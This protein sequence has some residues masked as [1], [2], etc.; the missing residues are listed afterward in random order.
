MSESADTI[1]A[2]RTEISKPPLIL[3]Q[4]ATNNEEKKIKRSHQQCN[5][6][7]DDDDDDDDDNDGGVL[8]V[9]SKRMKTEYD[10]LKECIEKNLDSAMKYAA[11]GDRGRMEYCL[12]RSTNL[13]EQT[14]E[15]MKMKMTMMTTTTTERPSEDPSKRTASRVRNIRTVIT[16]EKEDSYHRSKC[17]E[18]LQN[19][20]R[21]ASK[22]HESIMTFWL[23]QAEKEARQVALG[24]GGGGGGYGGGNDRQAFLQ[25]CQRR[26]AMIEKSIT[27]E[28]IEACHRR[29]MEEH[30]E[31][32]SVYAARGDRSTI[33]FFLRQSR[34]GATRVRD[35]DDVV[36]HTQ[37]RRIRSLLTNERHFHSRKVEQFLKE[38]RG[39]AQN[40]MRRQMMYALRKATEHSQGL[41]DPKD[42]IT[43]RIDTIQRSL[44]STPLPAFAVKADGTPLKGTGETAD[45]AIDLT[46]PKGNKG[47]KN[48]S[49]RGGATTDDGEVVYEKEVTVDERLEIRLQEAEATGKV[50][51]L[52]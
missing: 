12:D 13:A 4:E 23:K 18:C 44:I 17:Q 37:E 39:Y 29:I 46:S 26:M 42:D 28:Q 49:I 6:N 16:K 33:E 50:I 27:K 9:Q 32:A 21:Y 1:S 40:G 2:S 41:G 10:Y 47:K 31:R 22:G 5:G 52:A 15:M 48:L 34:E 8:S 36:F 51:Q 43:S 20:S 14:T 35:V 24:G 30:L 25:Q 38:A 11:V 7:D 19:A 45:D 3:K